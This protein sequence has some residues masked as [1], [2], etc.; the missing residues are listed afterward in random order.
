MIEVISEKAHDLRRELLVHLM[1]SR[2]RGHWVRRREH[3]T[4]PMY[5]QHDLSLLLTILARIS[6]KMSTPHEF[7]EIAKMKSPGQRLALHVAS[8]AYYMSD[9]PISDIYGVCFYPLSFN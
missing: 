4:S 6:I 3:L 8:W 2:N 7:M 9:R 5:S 1:I